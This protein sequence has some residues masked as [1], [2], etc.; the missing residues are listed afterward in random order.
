MHPHYYPLMANTFASSRFVFL[1]PCTVLNSRSLLF[2][3]FLYVRECV[4]KYREWVGGGVGEKNR[5][6]VLCEDLFPSA[7][8]QMPSANLDGPPK[9]LRRTGRIPGPT[10]KFV[11]TAPPAWM[12]INI[13]ST[14]DIEMRRIKSAVRVYFLRD[15][16]LVGYFVTFSC[17]NNFFFVAFVRNV[18]L[19]SS[20][21]RVMQKRLIVK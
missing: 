21:R 2:R 4:G 9:M 20:S 12:Q 1:Q 14:L 6:V 10:K 16:R 3:P 19:L 7:L 18:S 15:I 11:P 13:G 17:Q 8:R 5:Q